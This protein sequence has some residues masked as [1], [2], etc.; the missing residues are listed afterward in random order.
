MNNNENR[1]EAVTVQR[2]QG[3]GRLAVK[4][5]GHLKYMALIYRRYNLAARRRTATV[6][7]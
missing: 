2:G 5:A 4:A 7:C 3:V 6:D 1:N